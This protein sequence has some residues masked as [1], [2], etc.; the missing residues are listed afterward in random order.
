MTALKYRYA[1]SIPRNPTQI[2]SNNQPSVDCDLKYRY[3]WSILET[4][5]KSGQLKFFQ[6]KNQRSVDCALKYRYV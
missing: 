5:P 3:V 6:V 2:W 1:W 4:K